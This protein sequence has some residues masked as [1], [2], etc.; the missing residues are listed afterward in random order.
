[1]PANYIFV[2]PIG[3]KLI[4]FISRLLS[5][6]LVLIFLLTSF[7][8]FSQPSGNPTLSQII[9]KGKIT[10]DAGT[11]LPGV[12][13]KVKGSTTAVMTD[14][15]GTYSIEVPDNKS[16]LLFTFI[17]FLAQ[18]RTVGNS[19]I[20]NIS[21]ARQ[22]QNLNDVV[23]V[24]YGTQRREDVNGAISS[25]KASDIEDIPKVSID[26]L[27][28][29]KASGISVTQNSGAPGSQTS[30]RI[31]GITALTGSNEPLYVIDGVPVSGDASGNSPLRSNNSGQDETSVSPL[32]ALNPS[33]IESVDILKDASAT[34]I[35]GSRASNGVIM[36]TTKRG[37]MGKGKINYDGYYGFQQQGKFLDMM[38]L[39]QYAHLQNV[40]ADLYQQQRRGEF[41][42]PGLLGEGTNWQEEVFQT[43][44]MQNHQLSL[45][46]GVPGVT[47]YISGAYLDQQGTIKGSNFN[48]Y[49]FRANVDGQAKDWLKTGV[50][51]YGS[52]TNEDVGIGNNNGI[53]Y[54]ALLSAPDQTVYNADGTFSGPAADQTGGVINAVAQA[55]SLTNNLVRNNVGGNL[56]V[57]IGLTKD[58]KFRT[59]FGG[60]YNWSN[61]LIF[62]PSYSWGIYV[63]PTAN[64][65]EYWQQNS[66]WN[67][68][69]YLTYSHVF[70]KKHNLTVLLGHE[71]G[72]NN[73]NSISG[74]RQNF[75]SNDVQT[76]NLGDASTARND[77][78]KSSSFLESIYSR[79]FYT[80][81]NKYSI[82]AT[83]RADKSS[84]FA[85]GNQTGY[86]PSFAVSWRLSEE[87]FMENI[88]SVADK[89]KLRF[90]YGQVGNQSIPGYTYGSALTPSLTGL[91][92]GFLI[93]KIANPDVKWQSSIQT[94]VGIDLSLL[95]SRVQITFDWYYK[96]SKNFLFQSLLPNFLVGG[97]PG[98]GGINPPYINSGKLDNTGFEFTINSANISN[99]NFKWNSVLVFSQYTNKVSVLPAGSSDFIVG[100]V[101]NGYL[102]FT[103]TKTVMGGPVGEFFGYKVKDIFRSA[104]QLRKAPLQFGRSVINSS[105]GTWLGD[106]QY[107]DVNNDGKVD[108]QD[109]TFLGNPNPAFTYGFTNTFSYKSFD[110]SIFLQGAY[111]GEIVNMLNY[112]T[113]GLTDIYKNQLAAASDFWS[114]ANPNSKKPAPR[115]GKDNPN[116]FM[117]DRFLE[118]G[119]YLRIQNVMLG[120]SL[121]LK[122]IKKVK[123]NRFKIYVNA[124]NLYVF[125]NYSGL[126]PEIGSMNQSPFLTNIDIGRYP[127][128]RTITFGINAEF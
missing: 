124:Q 52:R 38:N 91:G 99:K 112:A 121:P 103:I 80:Y 32:A 15:S 104:D 28:Q 70:K 43:A 101:V 24:G 96:T 105:A 79:V 5:S 77:E 78:G 84:N 35:Y 81:S 63:N 13:V 31:R 44:P 19:R 56:Y 62:N 92:T 125:T 75:F 45:S 9:V 110:L 30:V 122:W 50:S 119:S 67:W 85:P 100:N 12:S 73:F 36:I 74:Y 42:D 51:I 3:L 27:L 10:D 86:F 60:Y 6:A 58:L 108:A 23:V 111:G 2:P 33:D 65:N 71:A 83:I 61:N 22:I 47:Y 109:Q 14:T 4:A 37:K 114:D 72:E 127:S 54:N 69:Q 66:F 26:Q 115:I 34:A 76:L 116:L 53:I 97:S 25:I 107:E 102:P 93:D 89:I 90:G 64:L 118:D 94:N 49:S 87:P 46:G 59:E 8:G 7:V 1:M 98:V 18:E 123:L 40:L 106:I 16:V 82:T 120:Y 20:I 48:R 11:A 113:N 57:D 88:R 117:S 95:K 126:D 55:L 17:G 29:G 128:P 39:Q 21:F 41:A 68:K